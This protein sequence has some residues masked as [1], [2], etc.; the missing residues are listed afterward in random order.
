[1][2]ATKRS[3]LSASSRAGFSTKGLCAFLCLLLLVSLASGCAPKH[4]RLKDE[5]NAL[6]AGNSWEVNRSVMQAAERSGNIDIALATGEAELQ[7]RPENDEARFAMARL[8]SRA[9]SPDQ[10]FSTL[11]GVS[12][13]KRSGTLF[14]LERARALIASN[15]AAEARQEL[16]SIG[17]PGASEREVRKLKGVCADLVGEHALAQETYRGLLSEQ[18]EGSV[19]FNYGRSLIA[20]RNYSQAASTLIPLVD[21][22]NYARARI[23]AAGAFMRSGDRTS[24]RNL[25][26]GYLSSSEI[27]DLL[28]GRTS[29]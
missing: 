9:G 6:K 20:S 3:L 25:L 1:M 10:A 2:S 11:E 17:G 12:D 4:A 21:N 24:A 7:A 14:K 29:L 18:E 23:L 19:R 15:R 5:H 26:D 16:D 22:P 28:A 8:Y 27:D 13:G